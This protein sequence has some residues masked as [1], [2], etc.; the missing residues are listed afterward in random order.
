MKLKQNLV[1]GTA[2][3]EALNLETFPKVQGKNS[4]LILQIISRMLEKGFNKTTLDLCKVF[5]NRIK[6]KA[7]YKKD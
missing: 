1:R 7:K 2:R 5:L 4:E 6:H 3:L